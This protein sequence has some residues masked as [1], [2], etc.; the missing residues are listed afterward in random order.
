MTSQE[1]KHPK[2]PGSEEIILSTQLHL[3]ASHYNSSD[4]P[5]TISLPPE[6]VGRKLSYNFVHRT[7]R[8]EKRMSTKRL[9]WNED[10]DKNAVKVWKIHRIHWLMHHGKMFRSRR[11]TV[12]R[13]QIKW[14][15]IGDVRRDDYISVAF[16][17]RSMVVATNL[18]L[19]LS[20]LWFYSWLLSLAVTYNTPYRIPSR[21]PRWRRQVMCQLSHHLSESNE[22]DNRQ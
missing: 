20:A 5:M 8:P 1:N 3:Y 22:T 18:K 21:T 16:T 11:K 12:L 4:P 19:F 14:M 7:A 13:K 15:I 2:A 6:S 17:V 10:I 9:N